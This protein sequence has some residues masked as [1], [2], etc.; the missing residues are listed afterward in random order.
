MPTSSH[1]NLI[2]SVLLQKKNLK[3]LNNSGQNSLVSLYLFF[4]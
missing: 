1:S 3:I 2:L 4:I